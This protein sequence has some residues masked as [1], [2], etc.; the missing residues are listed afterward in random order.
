MAT[1]SL[2]VWWQNASAAQIPVIEHC[3]PAGGAST[4]MPCIEHAKPGTHAASG[5]V[6]ASP[7]LG[8]GLHLFVVVSQ[9]K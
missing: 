7:P 1:Q 8:A 6:Q 9:T 5:P 3:C 2:D 4:Q